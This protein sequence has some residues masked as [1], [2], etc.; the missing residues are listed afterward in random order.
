MKFKRLILIVIIVVVAMLAACGESTK[1]EMKLDPD[2][3]ITL[4]LWHYYNGDQKKAF[5]E[6]VSEFNDTV[7]LE[8]GIIVE[9]TGQGSLLELTANVMDSANKKVGAKQMPD[10]FAAYADTAFEMDKLGLVA[11]LD[12][13]FTKEELS[14]YIPAYL[15]EGKFNEKGSLSIF[16]IAKS[17][18]VLMLNKTDWD[19]FSKA[20]G[21]DVEQLK[22]IEGLIDICKLYYDWTDSLTKKKEDGKAFF[23]R[24]AMAN[25]FTIGC[26]QLGIELFS[27]KNGSVSLNLDKKV[28]QKL[29]DSYYVPYINGY[30]GAN[31]KF[32]SDDAKTGDIL[33]FV[34]STSGATYFPNNVTLEDEVA[35]DIEAMI[36]ETPYFEEALNNKYEVQQGAGMVVMKSTELKHLGAVEFLK[37]FT[38]TERNIKFSVESGYLPVKIEANN[39]NAV[40]KVIEKEHLNN[41]SP[42]LKK[43]IPVALEV[44]NSRSMY[45]NKAFENATKARSILDYSLSDLAKEDRKKVIKLI[46]QGMNKEDAISK[47]D[48]QEHF[49]EW[50]D[51]FEEA[52]TK[53]IF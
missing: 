17:T 26:K 15:E 34:G 20:T 21:A 43:T 11:D 25:Y 38:Q 28:I 18:E 2:N 32:R 40:N 51:N 46:Q 47:F 48:T 12:T 39:I 7:G 53:L 41:L 49:N 9:A 4:E 8:K 23:G 19:K 5:D 30:F 1:K 33:A 22:T 52:L 37:W 35:Y 50:F 31:G 16:P 27:V 29:W 42:N 10:L 14:E 3:P 44:I 6:Q 24:D 13:Y 45:S 36:M